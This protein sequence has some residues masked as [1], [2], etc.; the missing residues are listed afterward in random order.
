MPHLRL[1]YPEE[2]GGALHGVEEVDHLVH[3][4]PLDEDLGP[5]L[6]GCLRPHGLDGLHRVP[7]A[8]GLDGPLH[9][10]HDSLHLREAPL[11]LKRGDPAAQGQVLVTELEE[12]LKGRTGGIKLVLGPSVIGQGGDE[13]H[14]GKDD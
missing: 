9:R 6:V 12:V 7:E 3:A 13:R 5:F 10:L 1:P 8:Q 11:L 2:H 14:D 4:H